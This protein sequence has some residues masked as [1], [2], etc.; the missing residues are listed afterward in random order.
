MATKFCG[1]PSRPWSYT[2][3]LIALIR[4]S[5]VI[6]FVWGKHAIFFAA[7]QGHD[8]LGTSLFNN[9]KKEKWNTYIDLFFSHCSTFA[10]SNDQKNN[11]AA[12]D[13]PI[14]PTHSMRIIF[15]IKAINRLCVVVIDACSSKYTVQKISAIWKTINIFANLWY[16]I[17]KADRINN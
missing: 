10:V 12:I 1:Y 15:K 11:V 5:R 9:P 4:I 6:K 3:A 8:H 16:D 7:R 2:I 17:I 13:L 14:P